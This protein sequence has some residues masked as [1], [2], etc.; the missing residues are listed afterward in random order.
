MELA[1]VILK[2]L[3][4]AVGSFRLKVRSGR[5]QK[6]W[7][8]TGI[9]S[10]DRQTRSESLYRLSYPGPSAVGMVKVKRSG[11]YMAHVKVKVK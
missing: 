6:I 9:R 7:P 11:L 10:P 2:I 8:P 5:V 1:T 4:F 3:H